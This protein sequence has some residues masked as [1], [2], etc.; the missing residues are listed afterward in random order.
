M[1]IVRG[2]FSNISEFKTF[3]NSVYD[4][5]IMLSSIIKKGEIENAS[6]PPNRSWCLND[7]MIKELMS[8]C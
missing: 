6:R 4:A 2:C 7:K 5:L 8:F 1:H 3:L